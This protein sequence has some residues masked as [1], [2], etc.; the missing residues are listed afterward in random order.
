MLTNLEVGKVA[1][2]W[3]APQHDHEKR[4]D[5]EP[6]DL[7]LEIHHSLLVVTL[8]TD[9]IEEDDHLEPNS[10][11]ECEEVVAKEAS[12]WSILPGHKTVRMSA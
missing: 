11:E 5:L 12:Y 1:K 10:Q 7:V 3:H 4:S 6:L 2:A 8:N 9:D